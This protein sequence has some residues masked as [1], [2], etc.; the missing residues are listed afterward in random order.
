MIKED[1]GRMPVIQDSKMA[2]MIRLSDLFV[3]IAKVVLGDQA[4][5]AIP[6]AP[7]AIV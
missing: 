1:V 4:V 2:G 7:A 5:P 6:D 3:E